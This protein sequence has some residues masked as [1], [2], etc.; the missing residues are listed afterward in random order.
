M[1]GMI[2]MIQ[3]GAIPKGAKVL[4]VHLGGSPALNGY[5]GLFV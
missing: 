4:Y 1:H 3:T 2:D 5:A